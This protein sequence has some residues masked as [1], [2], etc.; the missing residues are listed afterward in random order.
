MKASWV[1]YVYIYYNEYE[2]RKMMIWA[3]F[4]NFDFRENIREHCSYEIVIWQRNQE[5]RSLW[6]FKK[7]ESKNIRIYSDDS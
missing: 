4:L 1:E 7:W 2:L 6:N 5:R 3:F